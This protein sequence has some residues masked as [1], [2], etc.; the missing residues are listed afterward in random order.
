MHNYLVKYM[1][2]YNRYV[3]Y[4]QDIFSLTFQHIFIF[5]WAAHQRRTK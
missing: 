2:I 5:M 3:K 1:Y 4:I